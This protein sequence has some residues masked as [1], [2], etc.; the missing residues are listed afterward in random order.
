MIVS[1]TFKLFAEANSDSITTLF[2]PSS[3]ALMPRP[4]VI[5]AVPS[6]KLV[7]PAVALTPLIWISPEF[8]VPPP[9]PPWV[10]DVVVDTALKP[11]ALTE[12]LVETLYD[13]TF[14]SA[15]IF[16]AF[17]IVVVACVKVGLLELDEDEEAICFCICFII[18]VR[19]C[20]SVTVDPIEFV[21]VFAEV[22][23]AF[24]IIK[25][26]ITNI[27]MTLD[28]I[29]SRIVRPFLAHR[30]IPARLIKFISNSPFQ[31]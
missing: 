11:L 21:A 14:E 7:A 1:P 9:K 12:V 28:V 27:K 19:F 29:I 24:W 4:L 30:V 26:A 10:E 20:E 17:A 3:L 15:A 18:L 2:V 25:P 5:L 8:E 22:N 23:A 13:A 6:E 31:E 16:F